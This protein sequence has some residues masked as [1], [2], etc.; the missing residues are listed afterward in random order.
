MHPLFEELDAFDE[1]WR[2]KYATLY[3]AAKA[4]GSLDLYVHWLGTQEGHSYQKHYDGVP[5]Y[6][7]EDQRLIE[8]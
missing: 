7:A 6:H 5:V 4:A 8:E 3:D 1:R 2:Q